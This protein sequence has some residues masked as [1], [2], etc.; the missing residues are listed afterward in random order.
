M[1][2][3][4]GTGTSC[5]T[6]DLKDFRWDLRLLENAPDALLGN[7]LDHL[8][9]FRLDLR[10]W[11]IHG[12]I[13]VLLLERQEVPQIC[14]PTCTLAT[15]SVH[16]GVDLVLNTNFLKTSNVAKRMDPPSD[17]SGHLGEVRLRRRC[18]LREGELL[19]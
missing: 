6:D 19:T 7:G 16:Y 12:V 14:P 17:S 9:D 1:S 13:R 2:S 11:H 8:L 15:A 5:G 3:T 4:C 10:H 18:K